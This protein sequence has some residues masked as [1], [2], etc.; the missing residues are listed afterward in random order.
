MRLVPAS[1]NTLASPNV[2]TRGIGWINQVTGS[3][4]GKMLA[5]LRENTLSSVYVGTLAPD[6]NAFA[7]HSQADTR[8][9]PKTSHLRG[10]Q[11][12]QVSL[13]QLEFETVTQRYSNRPL[14]TRWLKM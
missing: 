6:S 2:L 13:L 3:A 9:K 11:I 5:F 7:R 1:G 14:T 4:D 12:R 8:R 10:H